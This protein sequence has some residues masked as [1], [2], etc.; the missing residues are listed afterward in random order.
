MRISPSCCALPDSRPKPGETEAT[1]RQSAR[2]LERLFLGRRNNYGFLSVDPFRLY[3][4]SAIDE[5]LD[6]WRA[7]TGFEPHHYPW[8]HDGDQDFLSE[9]VR[10]SGDLSYRELRRLEAELFTPL[11]P[12]IRDRFAFTGRARAYFMRAL[13]SQVR[14]TRPEQRVGRLAQ[15]QLWSGPA[16]GEAPARTR[17]R[18]AGDEELAALARE[19][20]EVTVAALRPPPSPAVARALIDVPRERF[21][22]VE[23][24]G[25]SPSD[26]ALPLGDDGYSTISALH[27][28]ARVFEALELG[29]GDEW[30]DLGGG[31]GY[32][33]A[34]GAELVGSSGRVTTIEV[35]RGLHRWARDLLGALSEVEAVC[36]DAHDT[37]LWRGARKVSAGF[38]VSERPAA[39]LDALGE[40]GRLVAPVGEA[41]AQRLLVFVKQGGSIQERDLGAVRY[42]GDRGEVATAES[43]A[44]ALR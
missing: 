26:V 13:D 21:V 11:L 20:R 23:D 15:W 5:D 28:Y 7:R 1:L 16:R 2:S 10:P 33:A 32:G 29:F 35:D 38:A 34:L 31:S 44:S 4:G 42:V 41:G 30:V 40:G 12:Q 14:L 22:R 37:S 43:D 19:A 25:R 24:I 6:G 8:W 27:A 3:P 9:W 18:V 36:A 17:Q 39:W